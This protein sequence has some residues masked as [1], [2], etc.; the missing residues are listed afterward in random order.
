MEIRGTH[1][2]FVLLTPLFVS[3]SDDPPPTLDCSCSVS[4]H[5]FAGATAPDEPMVGIER[6]ALRHFVE[7]FRVLE[8]DRRGEAILECSALRLAFS[9]SDRAGHVHLSAALT[10]LQ[11]GGRH[12]VIIA[13]MID[14]TALPVILEDLEGLLRFPHSELPDT[15]FSR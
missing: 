14:P 12:Q 15:G 8:R 1:N 11:A 5:R 3:L 10:E 2:E 6:E 4:S 9:V 13:F 7:E